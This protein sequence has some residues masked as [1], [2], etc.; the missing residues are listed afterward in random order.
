M[1]VDCLEKKT[2]A[3]YGYLC[4]VFKSE[5]SDLKKKNPH[6][7]RKSVDDHGSTAGALCTEENTDGEI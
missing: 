3:E 2:N 1:L 4:K 7:S 5:I 6:W